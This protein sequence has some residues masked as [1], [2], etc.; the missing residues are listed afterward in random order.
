MG[1][2]L[3]YMGILV[4]KKNTKTHPQREVANSMLIS[5][6]KMSPNLL[7]TKWNE[8]FCRTKT[9]SFTKPWLVGKV[10]I[11]PPTFKHVLS[12]NL[13]TSIWGKVPTEKTFLQRNTKNQ[14]NS[15]SSVTSGVCNCWFLNSKCSLQLQ[16]RGKWLPKPEQTEFWEHFPY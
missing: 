9:Q 3:T 1:F 10:S 2:F 7:S 11:I 13:A 15:P 14:S 8:L 4:R 6:R 12:V 5:R 16:A